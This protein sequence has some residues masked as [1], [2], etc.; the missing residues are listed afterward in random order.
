MDGGIRENDISRI[1]DLDR[2]HIWHHLTQHKPFETGEPRVI[3]EGKG[4]RIWDQKVKEHEN[5]H[6][7]NGLPL[8]LLNQIFLLAPL[9]NLHTQ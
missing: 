1:V 3:V 2:D 8:V 7:L 6:L 4:M 5:Y 9:H